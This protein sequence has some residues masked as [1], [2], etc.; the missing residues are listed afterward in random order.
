MR[1]AGGTGLGLRPGAPSLEN[2]AAEVDF[3][4]VR[5]VQLTEDVALLTY[6]VTARWE[7]KESEYPALASSIY[8]KRDGAWRLAFH[9]QSPLGSG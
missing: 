2:E 1:P 6:R 9:Q 3:K 7:H 5:T 4:E 8:V